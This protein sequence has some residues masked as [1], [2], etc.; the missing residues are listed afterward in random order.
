MKIRNA[1]ASDLPRLLE[2]YNHYIEKTCITFDIELQTLAHRK[3]WFEAFAKDGPHRLFVVEDEGAVAGYASSREFRS[4]AAYARSVE[5][6]IYLAPEATGRGLG[7]ALYAH[8]VRFLEAAPDVHRAVGG[9]T[10]PNDASVALHERMGFREVG[11]FNE[12]G[13]K[14][15]QYWDVAWF[16]RSV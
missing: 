2:I 6:S 13:F 12:I 16:E 7:R 9:I 10:L 8:L 15:D 1:E 11:R 14:F 3:A 5:T 4:R